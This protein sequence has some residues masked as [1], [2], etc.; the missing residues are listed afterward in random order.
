VINTLDGPGPL[1]LLAIL[2]NPIEDKAN[3]L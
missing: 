1:L 3:V 2:L